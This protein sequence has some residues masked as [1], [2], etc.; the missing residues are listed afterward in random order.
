M[1]TIVSTEMEV[2]KIE[3]P[4]TGASVNVMP[5]FNLLATLDPAGVQD[6]GFRQIGVLL[7]ENVIRC[8]NEAWYSAE[9]SPER[10]HDMFYLLYL[11]K[12]AFM[13]MEE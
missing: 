13:K 9:N 12:D 7:N 4:L 1:N 2:L 5:L 11:L 6:Q 8:L 3:N 10:S